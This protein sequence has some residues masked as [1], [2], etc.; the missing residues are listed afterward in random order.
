MNESDVKLLREQY[1]ALQNIHNRL[2]T[3]KREAAWLR[4]DM[5]LEQDYHDSLLPGGDHD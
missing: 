2:L 5:E 1:A 3:P 4:E